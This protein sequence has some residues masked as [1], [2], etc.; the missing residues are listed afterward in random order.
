MKRLSA[1]GIGANE[2]QVASIIAYQ[3]IH[4]GVGSSLQEYRRSIQ[5]SGKVVHEF[6]IELKRFFRR[7]DRGNGDTQR[8]FSVG[9]RSVSTIGNERR[10]VQFDPTLWCESRVHLILAY[11]LDRNVNGK[12]DYRR[13]EK[14]RQQ[15]LPTTAISGR[16]RRRRLFGIPPR[17]LIRMVHR[18]AP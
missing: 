12:N 15:R 11:Q 14:E 18:C 6:A 8:G 2:R 7:N 5:L 4:L 9:R 3:V 16:A 13:C 17:L 10:L 1:S